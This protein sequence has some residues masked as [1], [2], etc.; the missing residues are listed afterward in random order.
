MARPVVAA[1]PAE[2]KR[3]AE[4]WDLKPVLKEQAELRQI[5]SGRKDWKA[6]KGKFKDVDSMKRAYPLTTEN[7]DSVSLE[8][9]L[10][11]VKWGKKDG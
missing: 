6:N 3:D 9:L 8:L 5:A 2:I 10:K 1:T 11:S 7:M 4:R